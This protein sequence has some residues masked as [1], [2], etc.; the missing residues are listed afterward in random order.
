MK[1]HSEEAAEAL[2][3]HH[4]AEWRDAAQIVSQW[5]G[6]DALDPR[7]LQVTVRGHW[8]ETLAECGVTLLVT[9]EYEHLVMALRMGPRGPALS[10]LPLPHPSGLAVDRTRG[11]VHIASTRNPNQV[12]DLMPAADR[13]SRLDAKPDPQSDRPLVPVRTRFFPG[14]LYLHDLAWIGDTLHANAVGQNAIVRLDE[15][16]RYERVWWPR[17]IETEA[18]PVFGQNHLQLNSIAAGADLAGSYFS[19]S[20]DHISAR[21]PGH[22]N[23][24]VNKRGVIFSGATGEPIAR[25]LTRPHSAR[26]YNGQVWVDNSGYGE[27]GVAEARTFVPVACLPGWTRGLCFCGRIAFVGTSRVLPR[28]RQ[29]APGLDVDA[30]V[31]G[32][33]AL[34]TETG[35]NLG[36]LLWPYGNQIFAMDW[37]PDKFTSGLPFAAHGKRAV[38]R[39][40]QLF[41]TFACFPEGKP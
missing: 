28:F 20:T 40:K 9:R 16:G 30:S 35:K 10:F 4:H 39:E 3:A 41:Y 25:G 11:I 21:R 12:Y 29:Y 31:C 23:F 15:A 24:P 7:L 34:D 38:V 18:G 33:H 17:C 36:S 1:E 27:V 22:K 5:Q 19:A 2:W 14:C 32:L 6:A 8:W 37:L 26:L 13:L